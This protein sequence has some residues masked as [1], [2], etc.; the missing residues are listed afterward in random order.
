[1][2]VCSG[3]TLFLNTVGRP[4]L[5]AADSEEPRQRAAALFESLHER[6]LSL[7]DDMVVMPGHASVALPFDG[8]AFAAPLGDVRTAVTLAA[9]GQEE[10]VNAVLSRIPPTPPN[11]LQIVRINEGKEAR[12]DDLVS[13]EAGANRCAIAT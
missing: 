7:R 8:V 9:L 10:F 12:P 4:D 6:L 11:H 2:A 5:A 13:L 3:D 1:V